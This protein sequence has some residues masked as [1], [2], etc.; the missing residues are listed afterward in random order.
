M[1]VSSQTMDISAD[2]W[3]MGYALLLAVSGWLSSKDVQH[4]IIASSLME[5]NQMKK[6]LSNLFMAIAF[7]HLRLRH[8]MIERLIGE[9]T[10]EYDYPF[11][12]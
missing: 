1:S 5:V 12:I 10:L 4:L 8:W 7:T 6:I 11:E 2:S 9:S 3:N